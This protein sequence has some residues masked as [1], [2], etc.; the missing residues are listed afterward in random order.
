MTA[1]D[2][3]TGNTLWQDRT[4]PKANFVYADGKMVLVDED[5]TLALVT[6]NERG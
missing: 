4:F 2:V 3:K 1:V 5:G 6:V